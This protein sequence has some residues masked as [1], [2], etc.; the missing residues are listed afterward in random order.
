MLRFGFEWDEGASR[1]CVGWPKL[2]RWAQI[3]RNAST[4]I[5]ATETHA[6]G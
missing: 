1:N 4:L 6:D 2:L 3:P 5:E